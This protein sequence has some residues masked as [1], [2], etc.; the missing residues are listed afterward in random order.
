[1]GVFGWRQFIVKQEGHFLREPSTNPAA[2]LV[3]GDTVRCQSSLQHAQA[4]FG[5]PLTACV[6][7]L[8]ENSL[9][10]S[11]ASCSCDS[12]ERDFSG[13]IGALGILKRSVH[14]QPRHR[15]DFDTLEILANPA[16]GMALLSRHSAIAGEESKRPLT[17]GKAKCV[18]LARQDFALLRTASDVDPRDRQ[19]VQ[20]L[21]NS[22]ES[23]DSHISESLGFLTFVRTI[24]T[25]RGSG[26]PHA[27]TARILQG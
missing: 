5:Q 26:K 21:P 22:L 19:A 8:Q 3:L 27:D 6:R 11:A 20:P 25:S 14:L 12:A 9:G 17:A 10:G 23:H 13:E 18:L 7:H 15:T 2:D 4:T 1:V 24:N 16:R